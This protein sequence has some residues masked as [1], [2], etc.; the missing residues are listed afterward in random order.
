MELWNNVSHS[1]EECKFGSSRRTTV[2]DHLKPDAIEY[3]RDPQLSSAYHSS[4]RPHKGTCIW[5][6]EDSC[7][8]KWIDQKACQ[9]LWIHGPAG[10]GKSTLHRFIVHNL[11]ER[12]TKQQP[13]TREIITYYI[14]SKTNEGQS[15]ASRP[16]ARPGY[17]PDTGCKEWETC[18]KELACQLIDADGVLLAFLPKRLLSSRNKIREA[19]TDDCLDFIKTVVSKHNGARIRTVID[20]LDE[21][22]ED[23]RDKMISSL[24]Q[25]VH[26][27]YFRRLSI[28]TTDRGTLPAELQELSA[29]RLVQLRISGGQVRRDV[30]TFVESTVVRFANKHRIPPEYSA[31]IEKTILDVADGNFLHGRLAW[32][33]FS[34]GSSFWTANKIETSL[35]SLQRLP[36]STEAYY[37]GLLARVPSDSIEPAKFV[38]TLLRYGRRTF[39]VG[40]IQHA[41]AATGGRK[42]IQDIDSNISFNLLE[43]LPQL[44]GFLLHVVSEVVPIPFTSPIDGSRLRPA[45]T[46]S[47]V[48]FTHKSVHDLFDSH[49]DGKD[50]NNVLLQ[51]RSSPSDSHSELSKFCLQMLSLEDLCLPASRRFLSARPGYSSAHPNPAEASFWTSNSGSLLSYAIHTW[52]YH[53]SSS[54]PESTLMRQL[55]QWLSSPQAYCVHLLRKKWKDSQGKHN[56]WKMV[57]GVFGDLQTHYID[58]EDFIQTS[59]TSCERAAQM[60]ASSASPVPAMF[61]LLEYGDFPDVAAALLEDAERGNDVFMRTTPLSRALRLGRPRSVRELLLLENLV[62]EPRLLE[63]KPLH[64]ALSTFLGGG[65]ETVWSRIHN[66]RDIQNDYNSIDIGGSESIAVVEMLLGDPRTNHNATDAEGRTALHW[67]LA[68]EWGSLDTRQQI[69]TLLRACSAFNINAECVR[70]FTPFMTAFKSECNEPIVLDLLRNPDVKMDLM[71]AAKLGTDL[72][73]RAELMGWSAAED[74]L[75][76][77]FP[78]HSTVSSLEDGHS[79]F[80]LNAFRGKRNKILKLMDMIPSREALARSDGKWSLIGLCAQQDWRDIVEILQGSCGVSAAELDENN[81]TLL[82]WAT[83]N[84]WKLDDNYERLAQGPILDVQDKDGKTALQIASETSNADAARWLLDRGA[85]FLLPDKYGCSAVHAAAETFS[86]SILDVFL[87]CPTREFGRDNHGRSVLHSLAKWSEEGYL[88]LFCERKKFIIDVRDHDRRTPLHYACLTNNLQS[89]TALLLLGA[90]VNLRDANRFL[91]LHY[92][93]RNGSLELVQL[94]LSNGADLTPLT[95][96]GQNCLQLAIQSGHSRLMSVVSEYPFDVRHCDFRGRTILYD[97]VLAASN[98]LPK[99]EYAEDFKIL[100]AHNNPRSGLPE[101]F[102][103]ISR[104]ELITWIHL[105]SVLIQADL[106]LEK[107]DMHG[108]TPLHIAVER[109]HCSL[110]NILVDGFGVRLSEADNRGCTP[111][112]WA[113]AIGNEWNIKFLQNSGARTAAREEGRYMMLGYWRPKEPLDD[114][115]P[116]FWDMYQLDWY[117]P[118]H[119]EIW[120]KR[121]Y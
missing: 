5:I 57:P 14:F 59:K 24:A 86:R 22:C 99:T 47:V 46:R 116:G 73:Y 17:S 111:L 108:K 19:T 15:D 101:A 113:I 84:Q 115:P 13:P 45:P 90:S 69:W 76:T 54:S 70:G 118:R 79:L 11:W 104:S 66:R 87:E 31:K 81:R 2:Y 106:S 102:C 49:T 95:M 117:D 20:G 82:H 3:L 78:L 8:R 75:L 53:F 63:V 6:L 43:R 34:T 61:L 52:D 64:W 38:F 26:E 67:F 62:F 50:A 103:P 93:L 114:R 25:L 4:S 48:R 23:C 30:E 39:T 105:F 112:D 100:P 120:E 110:V 44:C 9:F 119:K 32:A 12:A 16:S 27:D 77:R 29:E 28:L 42:S 36:P 37:C 98:S 58:S 55:A 121:N 94:L 56:L 96:F 60:D 88:R 21:A 7:Y 89:A 10:A 40:E 97:C 71:R 83:F 91:P 109:E 85:S 72:L 74:E 80:T 33:Y 65:T 68:N 92:A 1:I 41:I 35:E 18:I 107:P 51:F